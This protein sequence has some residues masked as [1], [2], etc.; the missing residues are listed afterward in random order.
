M[1]ESKRLNPSQFLTQYYYPADKATE[2]AVEGLRVLLGL[3][4]RDSSRE[5]VSGFLVACRG[6]LWREDDLLGFPHDKN[7]YGRGHATY[8]RM[9]DE[10]VALGYIVLVRKGYKDIRTGENFVSTYKVLRF[11]AECK[12]PLRF[13]HRPPDRLL[14]IREHKSKFR[15]A[16]DHIDEGKILTVKQCR[17]R[18]GSDYDIE[19]HWLRA[20]SDYLKQHPLEMAGNTYTGF[21]RKFNNSRMDRGGRIYTGY[22]SLKKELLDQETEEVFYP[23]KTATIDGE[24]VAYIDISACFLCIRAAMAGDIIPA[25]KDPY[26]RI[27]FVVDK[28]SRGFAKVLV[29]AMIANGGTKKRYTSEMKAKLSHVIGNNKLSYFTDAIYDAYPFMREEVDGLEVMFIESE[30]MMQ[31][32]IGCMFSDMPVWPLHDALFVKQSQVEKAKAILSQQFEKKL[33]FPPRLG[34]DYL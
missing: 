9:R 18:F 29:S 4:D 8:K 33:G 7:A 21:S 6:L 28:P 27:S 2:T 13:V 12:T 14:T 31:T 26:S 3:Q 19:E 10:L 5:A 22:S 11:P 34:V 1:E 25:N 32:I 16:T 23:R 20:V 17:E 15:W 24:K 30:I